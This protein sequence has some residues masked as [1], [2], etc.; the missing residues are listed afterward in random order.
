MIKFNDLGK[1]WEVISEKTLDRLN[2]LFN[3]SSYINGPDVKIFEENFANYIGTNYAIGVSNGTDAIKLSVEAL[4]LKGKVGVIIP[5]NTFIATLLGVEMAIPHADFQLIDCD[6]YYQIDTNKL[7]DVLIGKRNKWDHCLIL[8]VHLYGHSANIL[9]IVK[10]SDK[11]NCTII[12]DSSQAHGTLS[13]EGIKVGNYG[14]LSA[15][16]LYP[17][18]NLGAAGDAGIITTNDKNLYDKLKMLQNWGSRKKYYY[19]MKG[20]NNRLDSIQAIILDEK[21]KYLDEWNE[22]RNKVAKWYEEYIT[23]NIVKPKTANYCKYNTYH[24]YPILVQERDKFIK[25]LNGNDIQN[26]IHYPIP[27][28]QTSIYS[29]MG[30]NNEKTR[31]F[32]KRLVSLPIHPFMSEEEVQ[33]VSKKINEYVSR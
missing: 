5:A 27:I 6:D 7:E 3:N 31:Y 32:S 11:Y 1:Q 9:E 12:E 17:G 21:L 23:V 14:L 19:D 26:V 25:Y 2:N 4:E 22:H 33:Y 18:K 8:P 24:V 15:F 20:Y 16:S 30:F 13:E 10:L 29:Y 28:E